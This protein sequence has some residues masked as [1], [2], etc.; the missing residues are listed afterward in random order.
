M[1]V[2]APKHSKVLTLVEFGHIVTFFMRNSKCLKDPRC[3]VSIV[4]FFFCHNK[5]I[6]TSEKQND[7]LKVARKPIRNH[8]SI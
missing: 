5:K 2:N 4:K 6:V 1:I 8:E 3:Q 7:L